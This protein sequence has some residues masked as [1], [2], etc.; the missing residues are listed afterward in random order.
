[1]SQSRKPTASVSPQRRPPTKSTFLGDHMSIARKT[2][3]IAL[4]AAFLSGL[5]A[6]APAGAATTAAPCASQLTAVKAELKKAAA[7]PKT[8]DA[9]KHYKAAQ[10]APKKTDDVTCVAELH[11]AQ[12]ALK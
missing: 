11:D 7:G 9:R 3:G 8:D 1:M 5:V 10:A 6:L 12:A 4:V 2:L